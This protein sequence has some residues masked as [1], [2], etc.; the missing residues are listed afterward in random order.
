MTLTPERARQIR[1]S[2]A[3]Q[4]KPYD[5][6]S[7]DP[8][9]NGYHDMVAL[10]DHYLSTQG[11]DKRIALLESKLSEAEKDAERYRWLRK[12]PHWIHSAPPM[13]AVTYQWRNWHQDGDL[14][15]ASIDAA[16]LPKE[17]T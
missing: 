8:S 2:F 3:S 5:P 12:T 10:C 6:Y 1:E 9:C 15:D 4:L 7:S 14:L 17:T 11:Q 13:R 16:M